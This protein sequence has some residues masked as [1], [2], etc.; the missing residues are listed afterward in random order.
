MA[1]AE[2]IDE[3][4]QRNIAPRLDRAVEIADRDFTVALDLLEIDP[5]VALLEREDVGR[6]PDPFVFVEQLDLLLA[7]PFD[8]EGAARHEM[9][10]VF[11]ALKR[12]GEFAG[13]MGARALL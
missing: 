5:L 3:K 2:R 1:D 13:A 9:P 12:A 7:E 4:L 10:Q 11:L 6:L 8:V